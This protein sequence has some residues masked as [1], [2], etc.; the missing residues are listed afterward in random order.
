[1]TKIVP[2]TWRVNNIEEEKEVGIEKS[3]NN[4]A[5][6]NE[7]N[8][9]GINWGNE[10]VKSISHNQEEVKSYKFNVKSN[11]VDNSKNTENIHD[12]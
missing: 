6:L 1:M 3:V 4:G 8:N 7:S 5:N 10:S 12:M 11:N 2:F 9:E